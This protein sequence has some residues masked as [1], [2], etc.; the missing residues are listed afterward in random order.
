[1]EFPTG[2]M[3]AELS[4]LLRA[5]LVDL[6]AELD[7]PLTH[8]EEMNPR[9]EPWMVPITLIGFGGHHIA[10]SMMLSAS[11]AVLAATSPAQL[12]DA[13]DLVDW[14][15]ELANMALGAFKARL[16]ARGVSL[17]IGLPTSIGDT[18]L[19]VT[20]T[21]PRPLGHRFVAGRAPLVVALDVAIAPGLELQPAG[22]ITDLGDDRLAVRFF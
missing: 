7:R 4:D 10:G 11:D 20:P 22:A 8:L 15:C 16:A 18:D 17:E 1:M 12:G 9:E 6:F 13:G 19:R 21:S 3:R 14:S 2:A 5:A